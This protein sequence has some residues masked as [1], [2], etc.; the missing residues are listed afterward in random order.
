[1]SNVIENL[2]LVHEF[3]NKIEAATSKNIKTLRECLTNYYCD[4]CDAQFYRANEPETKEVTKQPKKSENVYLGFPVELRDISICETCFKRVEKNQKDNNASHFIFAKENDQSDPDDDYK[5][6]KQDKC[7]VNHQICNYAEIQCSVSIHE[8]HYHDPETNEFLCLTHGFCITKL[9]D[10]EQKIWQERFKFI[11]TD[12][13]RSTNAIIDMR[14]CKFHFWGMFKK[15]NPTQENNSN[16]YD[17]DVS[18][19]AKTKYKNPNAKNKLETTKTELFPMRP[20]Y[21]NIIPEHKCKFDL[22]KGWI[23][24]TDPQN[25]D[26]V[27][28]I[29]LEHEHITKYPSAERAYTFN[30]INLSTLC[31][32]SLDLKCISGQNVNCFFLLPDKKPK[33]RFLDEYTPTDFDK[34][35]SSDGDMSSQTSIKTFFKYEYNPWDCMVSY[36]EKES[37]FFS[38]IN[39]FEW[40]IDET[41]ICVNHSIIVLINIAVE[42]NLYG[43]VATIV[44]DN[45][46]QAGFNLTGFTWNEYKQ[47]RAE[48]EK[49]IESKVCKK[50][51]GDDESDAN[52]NDKPRVESKRNYLVYLRKKLG[53]A[54]EYF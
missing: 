23:R 24:T 52:D 14:P 15:T 27:Y 51:K 19:L 26:Y 35:V 3:E 9:N 6:Q 11:N 36:N 1:M 40:Y 31:K 18:L 30:T 28:N 46:G 32:F 44:V 37:Q 50:D 5:G 34:L 8:P 33:L 13:K 21:Y 25:R 22:V 48:F 2:K 41:D 45:T 20:E 29:C 47:D 53:Q 39:P 12:N 7:I 43:Q 49:T 10:P 54:F 16:S 38:Q 4:I 42:S 17:D